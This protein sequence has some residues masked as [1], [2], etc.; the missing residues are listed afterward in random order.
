MNYQGA[1]AQDP[2]GEHGGVQ[3]EEKAPAT[4]G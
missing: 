4:P 3:Q 2:A 1:Q